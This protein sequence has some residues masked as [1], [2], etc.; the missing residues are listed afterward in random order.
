[1]MAKSKIC[2]MGSFVV[3][4]ASKA[5][6]L[7]KRGETVIGSS[8]VMGPGGKGSNQ[9][10]AA[11]RAG[12]DVTF[13]TKIGKDVFGQLAKDNFVKEGLY[14]PYIFEDAEVE[15]GTALILVDKESANSI[16]VVPGACENITEEE[17]LACQEEL[18]TSDILLTQLEVNISATMKAIEIAKAAGSMVV[19]NPAPVREIPAGLLNQIDIVTPNEM[20]AAVLSGL[21][22]VETIEDCRKAAAY[23]FEQGV[24]KVIITWGHNGAY[25]HDGTTEKHIPVLPQEA[26]DTTG[27]GDAFNGCFVAA[28]AQGK[29]FFDAAIYATVGASISVTRFG[30][31]PAM[32]YASEIEELYSDF[33]KKLEG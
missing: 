26:I 6:H 31:A 18:A 14:S 29:D 20:E 2:V 17:V 25:C 16:L 33:K 8:F 22:V 24:K 32:A 13:I 11:K 1:M 10:V 5:E 15:T 3:D 28:L 30:T 27:A 9:A 7:P 19:L 21:P 12:A 4:L 23:F